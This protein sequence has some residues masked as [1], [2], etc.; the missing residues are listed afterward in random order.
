MATSKS[1]EERNMRPRRDAQMISLLCCCCYQYRDQGNL[2]PARESASICLLGKE[3]CWWESRSGK[4]TR[5]R[6]LLSTNKL[7]QKGTRRCCWIDGWVDGCFFIQ[8]RAWTCARWSCARSQQH[9]FFCVSQRAPD[10]YWKAKKIF[11]GVGNFSSLSTRVAM[12]NW[13][14]CDFNRF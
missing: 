9:L 5:A 1:N 3:V 14:L 8:M 11:T 6:T 10:L 13:N 4:T 7:P 12:K 2:K